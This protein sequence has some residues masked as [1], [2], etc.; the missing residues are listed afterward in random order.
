[1]SD[2]GGGDFSNAA[3]SS[4]GA[5]AGLSHDR[6]SADVAHAGLTNAGE[7]NQSHATGMSHDQVMATVA[8]TGWS[9]AGDGKWTPTDDTLAAEWG[10]A[11][12]GHFNPPTAPLIPPPA[13]AG[14]RLNTNI[15]INVFFTVSIDT[16]DLG[17]WSKCTGLG[18]KID[19]KP[20][21]EAG[22][23]LFQHQLPNHLIYEHITLERPLTR[24]CQSVLN[25]FMAYHM[26]PIPTSGQITATDQGGSPV[27]TWEL[28]GVTP[29]AWKGPNFDATGGDNVATESLTIAHTGFF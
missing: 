4:E 3:E 27:M 26:L 10:N 8:E 1:M 25:W 5:S 18:M 21:S 28:T 15:G 19:T 23:T 14:I 13:Q 24:D 20:R 22:M 9:N 29:V 6:V 2:A 7:G 11:G 16:V 17:A 12:V